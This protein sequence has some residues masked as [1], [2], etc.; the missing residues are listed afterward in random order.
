M[1]IAAGV[2]AEIP[3]FPQCHFTVRISSTSSVLDP[4]ELSSAELA[5]ESLAVNKDSV[6]S[7]DAS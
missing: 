4:S 2:T 3:V 5:S 1:G 6:L 7:L